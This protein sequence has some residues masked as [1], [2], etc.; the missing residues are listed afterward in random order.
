MPDDATG[1]QVQLLRAVLAGAV[2]QGITDDHTYLLGPPDDPVKVC[3]QIED[4]DALGW[5]DLSGHS[6]PETWQLTDAGWSALDEEG[7]SDG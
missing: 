7:A 3:Q 5:V 6:A 4:M 2:V 1:D